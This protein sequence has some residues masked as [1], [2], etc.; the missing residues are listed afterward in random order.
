MRITVDISDKI[1]SKILKST[2]EK[3]KS[4]ALAKALEE[5]VK[6]QERE[7]FLERVLSGQTDYSTSNEKIEELS[8]LSR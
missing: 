1:V 3:K 6:Y 8:P 5:Y 4:P 2:G 7:A